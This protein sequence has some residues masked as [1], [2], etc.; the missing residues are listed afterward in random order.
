MQDGLLLRYRSETGVDGLAG[1]EHPFLACSFWLVEQYA[2]SG[3]IAEARAFMG[4]LVSLVNDVGLLSEE[5]DPVRRRQ[6][7]NVPQ[8][9]VAPHPRPRGGC[10]RRGGAGQGGPA[11]L[12]ARRVRGRAGGGHRAGGWRAPSAPQKP[13]KG[14][15]RDLGAK[16]RQARADAEGSTPADAGRDAAGEQPEERR[17]ATA[18]LSYQPLGPDEPAG[19]S[20]RGTSSFFHARSTGPMIRQHSSAMSA[21]TDSSGSPS[22]MPCSTCP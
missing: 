14:G 18:G 16:P 5:Y 1:D 10:H 11:A 21:R 15:D 8:A 2:A 9:L 3:L 4:R 12:R 19:Y 22:R 13:D 17:P 7:G 20:S 6:M